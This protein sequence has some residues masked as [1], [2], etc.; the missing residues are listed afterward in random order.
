MSS[1]LLSVR[2]LVLSVIGLGI[3][4]AGLMSTP[5]QAGEN[6]ALLVGVSGYPGL[7]ERLRLNRGV[8]RDPRRDGPANDV[9]LIRELLVQDKGFPSQ[10]VTVLADGIQ[11]EPK[12]TRDAILGGLSALAKKSGKGDFVFLFFAGHGSQQPVSQST[13]GVSEPDGFDEIFLPY[14]VSGWN[15]D[16]KEVQNAILD[17]EMGAAITRIRNTGAFVWVVFDSCHSGT[18][19]R[20][21]ADDETQT[22]YVDPIADLGIP[23]E[24]QMAAQAKATETLSRGVPA[25]EAPIE[26]AVDL[27]P[28]AGGYVGFFAVQSNQQTQQT[29][30]P[31]RV[32]G[33]KSHGWFTFSIAQVVRQNQAFRIVRL[34]NAFSI[35]I[36]PATYPIP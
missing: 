35:S 19:T 18:M 36:I 5:V 2:T 8:D 9:G 26:D 24:A 17:D 25:A 16:A 27:N 4:F 13:E 15:M 30:L 21:G 7:S 32:K 12:P 29:M 22:R 23:V 10:N 3:V 11:G 1:R 6:R 28:G 34:L 31:R 20:G 33:R 14:D